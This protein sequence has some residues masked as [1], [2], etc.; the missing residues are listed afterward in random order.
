MG[1]E[2]AGNKPLPG[3]PITRR[4]V[5]AGV[6]AGAVAAGAGGV[7]SACGS[8]IKGANSGSTKLGLFSGLV[9]S[10]VSHT[11]GTTNFQVYTPNA[12][13]SARGTRPKL[14]YVLMAAALSARSGLSSRLGLS[15]CVWPVP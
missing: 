11:S 10:I 1:P 5:L 12:V 6:G 3:R 8:G 9:R 2:R 14:L 7:L 15:F 4:S 13:A